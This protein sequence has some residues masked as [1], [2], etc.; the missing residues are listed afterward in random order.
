MFRWDMEDCFSG[1][2]AI[3]AQDVEL[4]QEQWGGGNEE[5][6][7]PVLHWYG[8]WMTDVTVRFF[9]ANDASCDRNA[10]HPAD[11]YPLLPADLANHAFF[12]FS[13]ED[14]DTWHRTGETVTLPPGQHALEWK[15]DDALEDIVEGFEV[16]GDS[17]DGI[18]D[19]PCRHDKKAAMLLPSA[20]DLEATMEV[21]VRLV[22]RGKTWGYPAVPGGAGDRARGGRRVGESEVEMAGA[23][24][25]GAGAGK[26]SA[27][28]AGKIPGGHR[29]P[30]TDGRGN[31]RGAVLAAG[32]FSERAKD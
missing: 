32:G 7:K 4:A 15:T 23:A 10:L 19:I 26:A 3:T 5:D 14:R 22:P 28:G 21:D 25:S 31:P 29:I 17:R 2:V 9:T 27:A 18:V 24:L 6:G 11:R 13:E 1:E 12:R 16:A 20:H 8:E 30:G